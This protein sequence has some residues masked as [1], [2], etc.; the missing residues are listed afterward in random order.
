MFAA[1]DISPGELI[2]EYTGVVLDKE[3]WGKATDELIR[4]T[5]KRPISHYFLEVR[6]TLRRSDGKVH[7]PCF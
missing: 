4:E 7:S 5:T 1:V 2:T 6:E 3:E